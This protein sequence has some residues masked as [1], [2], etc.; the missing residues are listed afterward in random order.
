MRDFTVALIS[1]EFPP[2]TIGGIASYCS[3]LANA[4]SKKGIR[5]IVFAG[6]SKQLKISK[7]NEY[8]EIVRMPFLDLPPRY[9]WFQEKNLKTILKRIDKDWVIHAVN[10]SCCALLARLKKK[11]KFPF[12]TTLHEHPLVALKQFALLSVSG[13]TLGD[14]GMYVA[15]YPLDNCLMQ[16]CLRK[17][18]HIIVPGK[19]TKDYLLRTD[20]KILSKKV[21]VIY[22]GIDLEQINQIKATKPRS[23]DLSLISYGRLITTKGFLY[24]CEAMPRVLKEFPTLKVKLIGKGPMEKKI[25]SA[26][27]KSNAGNMIEYEGF[28]PHSELIKEIKKSD[29]VVLPTFHE[30]GPF[31]SALEA[32]ACRKTLI[33]F[34]SYFAREF[35]TNMH[36][37]ILSKALSSEDLS[38]KIIRALS[39]GALRRKLGEN[40]YQYIEKYHNWDSL[41]SQYIEM[42]ERCLRF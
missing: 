31:I 40:A 30:V 32:M 33:V 13:W 41:V 16:T 12:V 34:D 7:M 39:D 15:S 42:Y 9:V 3:S 27:R 14:F 1:H 11:L 10:P 18:D 5:T 19:F 36:N 26:I 20:R 25:I 8:L 38:V 21:S 2:Y 28:R 29:V 17:S 23:T 24:L 6:L 37:G 4:L 22:N 35:V